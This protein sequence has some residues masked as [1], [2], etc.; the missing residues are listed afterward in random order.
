VSCVFTN[1]ER[2]EAT[3]TAVFELVDR[4]TITAQFLNTPPPEKIGAISGG[5][6]RFT[7]ADGIRLVEHGDGT[8]EITFLLGD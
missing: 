3:C 6:G 2:Q 4:G 8:G 7:G 5:T 1:V